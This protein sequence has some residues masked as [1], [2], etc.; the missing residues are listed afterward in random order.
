MKLN[1]QWYFYKM[2]EHH[3]QPIYGSTKECKDLKVGDLIPLIVK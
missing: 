2:G 1:Y 3:L